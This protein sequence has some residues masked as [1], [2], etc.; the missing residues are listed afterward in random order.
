[1]N[2]KADPVPG[3]GLRP[4]EIGIDFHPAVSVHYIKR[5]PERIIPAFDFNIVEMPDKGNGDI[6]NAVYRFP[7]AF[8]RGTKNGGRYETA[9]AQTY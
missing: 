3:G 7:A 6:Q 4:A 2:L 1:M 5:F 8:D 9:T